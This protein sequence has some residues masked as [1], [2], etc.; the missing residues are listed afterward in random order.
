MASQH[1]TSRFCASARPRIATDG[2]PERVSYGDDDPIGLELRVSAEGRKTWSF[3]YRTH[4]GR[5]RRLTL[6]VFVDG[7]DEPTQKDR[8][9]VGGEAQAL[10]LRAARRRARQVRAT[11]EEGGD[12]AAAKQARKAT[13]R[14]EPLKTFNDLADAYMTACEKGRWKP[15]RKQKRART[16]SDE[17]GI[18]ARNVRPTI[19][20]LRL[21]DVSKAAVRK[22]LDAMLDRG[23]GAQTNRTHAVIRQVLA[24]G[25][26][27]ERLTVNVAVLWCSV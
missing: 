4:D 20:K 19:G 24:Y 16:L 27:Q 11:A 13:A 3:R 6:G 26:A 25:V 9:A 14:A 18:L 2:D 22:V 8:E 1:L 12:P 15:R 5:Q 17:T 10:T 21:E 23:V 7:D